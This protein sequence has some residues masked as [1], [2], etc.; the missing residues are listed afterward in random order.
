[1]YQSISEEMINF[2][3]ASKDASAL[4]N[5]VGDP[6]NRY[7]MGF[8]SMEKV[9]EIFFNTVGNTPDLEKYLNYYKWL[10]D[11]ITQMVMELIPASAKMPNVR[12]VVES[13]ILERNKYLSKFPTMEGK[14]GIIEDAA[15]G[16]NELTYD[17][18]R[19]HAPIAEASGGRQATATVSTTTPIIFTST[20]NA[21]GI[22][23]AD[24]RNEEKF[25]LMF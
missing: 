10:D 16:V 2:F 5:I 19:G 20:T 13:H 18:Q 14:L 3:M 6:V 4:E 22:Q 17:W 12:N 23:F 21:F 1:M 15:R 7:R 8:K 25:S 11:S 24:S 9:R